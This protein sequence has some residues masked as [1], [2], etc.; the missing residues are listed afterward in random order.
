MLHLDLGAIADVLPS[1]DHGDYQ[2]AFEAVAASINDAGGIDGRRLELVFATLDPLD[3]SSASA[4][5][6][7]LTED[8]QVFAVVAAQSNTTASQC[9]LA[10][11]RGRTGLLETIAFSPR[12]AR[13]ERSKRSEAAELIDFLGLG[14][15]A[16]R[17]T[18][19]L[20]TGTRRIVELAG[21]LAVD[22]RLLCLDEPTA[23]IAQRE[24]EAMGPL[25]VEVRRHLS[26]SM[27]VIEHDMPLI[28]S[29]SDRVYC[30]ELGRVIAEGTPA[31]VRANPAVVASFLGTDERTIARSGSA[32]R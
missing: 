26:A 20:S 27:L 12:A 28:M 6:T 1:L 30:V 29:M 16:D 17:P 5:C 32:A 14:R 25:L 10:E 22:A 2:S 24:A 3:Q 18:G 9:I 31:E 13:R 7:R 21:L 15:Y 19:E 8:E 4:A 11:A 23:G